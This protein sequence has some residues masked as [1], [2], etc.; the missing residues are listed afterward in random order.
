VIH[1]RRFF[2]DTF[3]MI[4]FSTI[5]GMVI[6][7]LISGLT[8]GQS[9]QARLTAVPANLLTGR[10]YGIYRDWV[11]RV[12]KAKEGG[13]LRKGLADLFAFVTFQVTLYA[14]ILTSTGA[15]ISQ[16]VTACGTLT[17]LSVFMGRPY[18]MFLDFSRWLF[19]ARRLE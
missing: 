6:E 13:K 19:R 7:I 11:L 15:R 12:T 18:G 9:I 16:I 5:G 4:T 17:V 2:A 8:I 3:A 1:V 14:I 10:P